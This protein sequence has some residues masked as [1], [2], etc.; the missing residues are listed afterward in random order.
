MNP[1]LVYLLAGAALFLAVV[2][3]V[4]LQRSAVSAPIVLL[5]T[6]ALM[7]LLVPESV[8]VGPGDNRAFVEH[9]TEFTVIVAL[10]G[11]GLALDRPLDLRRF[12][13]WRKWSATWRLLGI[14]MPLTIVLVAVLGAWGL[15][16]GVASAVLLGAVLAPTDPVLASAMSV[17]DADDE[18]R[19]RYGLSGEAG[20]NDGMAFPFVVFAML[21]TTHGGAGSWIVEWA[22]HRLVWAVPAGL[23]FGFGAGW[24]LGGLAVKIRH[25]EENGAA[26]SD[27]LAIGLIALSYVGAELIGAWGFLSVF[28]AGL[29]LRHAERQLQ[30]RHRGNDG[31]P[32]EHHVPAVVDDEDVRDPVAAAGVTISEALAF[33]HTLE[34]I[35]E[36]LTVLLI[37]AALATH[38]DVRGV[39]LAL[40]LFVVIRPAAAWMCLLAA[41]VSPSQRG[42]MA[43]FGIRG[44]GSLYYLTYA[45]T[46]ATPGASTDVATN[47]TL[48]VVACSIVLHGLTGQ[49]SLRW[50]EGRLERTYGSAEGAL[51][52]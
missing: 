40:V 6:G 19:M 50:Y 8:D 3:P 42:L 49:P 43:W 10:M 33:G 22:L 23:V 37:G 41:P 17:T 27:F 28:A 39:V 14:A 13:S 5:I 12:S 34:R 44:I 52:K 1:D 24:L 11:V 36:A 4:A 21:W 2:L 25:T 38:W 7:G 20:F 29:G 48:V 46:H 16:L 31:A 30:L 9:L 51:R 47:I 26:P 32:A 18:D 45:I 35:L 15:G